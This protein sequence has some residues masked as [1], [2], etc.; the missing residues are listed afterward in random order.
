MFEAAYYHLIAVISGVDYAVRFV[1]GKLVDEDAYV[2][3]QLEHVSVALAPVPPSLAQLLACQFACVKFTHLLLGQRLQIGDTI[4]ISGR[5]QLDELILATRYQQ[6]L[7]Q[8]AK[9][10]Q[11]WRDFLSAWQRRHVTKSLQPAFA[12]LSERFLSGEWQLAP[13]L[14][15]QR[16][17]LRNNPAL[18]ALQAAEASF[19]QPQ[20]ALEPVLYV[21]AVIRNVLLT[22]GPLPRLVPL[23]TPAKGFSTK[24]QHQQLLTYFIETAKYR[25]WQ[26]R[27]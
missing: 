13:W 19:N 12:A 8:R 26:R 22:P 15:A 23:E 18:A 10:Q 24:Q 16:R 17:L 4:S 14:A 11:A 25:A 21:S 5:A 20:L 7:A 9:Q 27:H 1:N 3:L 6:V 2:W